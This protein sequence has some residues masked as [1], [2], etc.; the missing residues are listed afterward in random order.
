MAL[1]LG[2]LLVKQPI[3][4]PA[5]GV[6]EAY[7]IGKSLVIL[8]KMRVEYT[9]GRR[10]KREFS[11]SQNIHNQIESRHAHRKNYRAGCRPN[12]FKTRHEVTFSVLK[13]NQK[14]R[15]KVLCEA[16]TPLKMASKMA[17]HEQML[18]EAL[19]KQIPMIKYGQSLTPIKG[20]KI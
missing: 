13:L 16:H 3:I 14:G 11:H 1:V 6:K 19:Q 9:A 5:A 4:Q 8:L 2:K 20:I 17:F 7:P 18:T 12:N 15:K 10:P